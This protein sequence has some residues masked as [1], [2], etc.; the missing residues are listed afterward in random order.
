[1]YRKEFPDVPIVIGV[2]YIQA[3]DGEA[4]DPRAQVSSI[5]KKLRKLAKWLG[6]VIVCVSQTSRGNREA[7][8]SGTAV[9]ADT[10]TMGAETSQIERDAYVTMALGNLELQTDGTTKMD[11][12]IG[13]TRM[14]QGDR[15]YKLIYD[16]ASGSFAM[17]GD[18]RSGPRFVPSARARTTKRRS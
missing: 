13:K 8:R 1:V 15:V 5:S 9:G 12:N 4:R 17:I 18:V 16:G 6:A 3:I 11:L 2:D 7:L 14:G 10:V